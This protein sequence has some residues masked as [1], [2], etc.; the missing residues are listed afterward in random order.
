MSSNPSREHP[1]CIA[2]IQTGFDLLNVATNVAT[3]VQTMDAYQP[4]ETMRT[5]YANAHAPAD[6]ATKPTHRLALPQCNQGPSG[7]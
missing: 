5:Q 2:P 4:I 6:Q 3:S 1:A 7:R